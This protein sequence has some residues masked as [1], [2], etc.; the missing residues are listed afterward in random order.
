[1]RCVL[2]TIPQFQVIYSLAEQNE[3]LWNTT[4]Q[5]IQVTSQYYVWNNDL[6]SG[7][8]IRIGTTPPVA[9]GT[10]PNPATPL[11]T[12]SFTLASGTGVR[13]ISIKKFTTSGDMKLRELWH[14]RQH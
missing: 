5:E 2:W 13:Y 8:E 6:P 1:M 9:I 10:F 14:F 11:T 3:H 12:Y 4:V 7:A